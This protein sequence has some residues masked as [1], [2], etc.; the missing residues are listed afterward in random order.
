MRPPNV[1]IDRID[2]VSFLLGV[3]TLTLVIVLTWV[4]A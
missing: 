3:G 2:L 4:C 1:L